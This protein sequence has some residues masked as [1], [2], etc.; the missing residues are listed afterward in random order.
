MIERLK[1][2][3]NKG[4]SE[5]Y[6]NKDADIKIDVENSSRPLP[7]NDIDTT[8]S[9]FEQFQ[10]EREESNTYRFYG[11]VSPLIS[12]PLY[13]DNIHIYEDEREIKSTKVISNE[14]FE[15]D[16][17]IGHFNDTGVNTY[18]DP[19]TLQGMFMGPLM[20]GSFSFDNIKI[21]KLPPETDFNNFYVGQS[22]EITYFNNNTGTDVTHT[23]IIGAVD[24]PNNIIYIQDTNNFLSQST[25]G[26]G[27]PTI[28]LNFIRDGGANDYNDNK[29]SICNFQPFDPG[30]DRLRLLDNDKH[31]NY[32]LKLTYPQ[33]SRDDIELI[34]GL[35]LSEGIPIM[36]IQKV[37][38]NGRDYTS[39]RT[40]IN[41]GLSKGDT[42]RLKHVSINNSNRTTFS[43]QR[44]GDDSN[45]N[46]F[47]MFVIDIDPSDVT[48]SVGQST[49]NRI[50]NGFNSQYYVRVFSGLTETYLDYDLY[51]AGYA[52]NYYEDQKVAFNFIKDIDIENVKDNLGR[53][54]SEIFLTIIKNNDDANL[55]D[56]RTQ[57]WI[58]KQ[59][60]KGLSTDFW[61]PIRGGFDIGKI[62]DTTLQYNIKAINDNE[63]PQTHFQNID[64]SDKSFIGDIVEYN[65]Y[66]L[67]ERILENSY[68]W[69]NTVYRENYSLFG[70]PLA[71]GADLINPEGDSDPPQPPQD[72]KEGYV[73]QPHN[74][75]IIK[76]YS[77]YIESGVPGEV[78][79]IPD[80][81]VSTYIS[82]GNTT[83]VDV[84]I[85]ESKRW[86]DMLS[87]GFMDGAGRGVDYPFESG[88]HYIFADTRFYLRRQDPA[89]NYNFTSTELQLPPDK[90][91]FYQILS[92]PSYF[93]YTFL[94][95]ELFDGLNPDDVTDLGALTISDDVKYAFER[96][97][98]SP[99]YDVFISL[100]FKTKFSRDSKLETLTMPSG[101]PYSQWC[102][103][104]TDKFVRNKGAG[105]DYVDES[106]FECDADYA[107][108]QVA[109]K[110]TDYFST[111]DSL[112]PAGQITNFCL[113]AA[114]IGQINL[115]KTRD[116]S[117]ACLRYVE[118]DVRSV[119]YYGEYSLGQVDTPG[120]CID[121]NFIE[122]KPID[123]DC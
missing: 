8:V 33:S 113:E 92:Q 123:D 81:A 72:K 63:Y 89:C 109:T 20:I 64:E 19:I 46:Q 88:A 35:P 4:R 68:H 100:N 5:T 114:G 77:S 18:T 24:A 66:E 93:D 94:N 32:L 27:T 29:S 30:Y 26:D 1:I 14:I 56:I 38:M 62:E 86:R 120:S 121:F 115:K 48:I 105:Q 10:K 36:E 58:D 21:I 40:P 37:R 43:V 104:I 65:E 79:N 91:L 111:C 50:V 107:W 55:S 102:P 87:V 39:F 49:V 67:L 15:N 71:L 106:S 99:C 76:E 78:I 42:I 61:V 122:E 98:K 59:S 12:N 9:S 73:Y 45:S 34:N 74:R 83:N 2:L 44:L 7:L 85:K 23:F 47:R 69:I 119:Q 60:E 97:P 3:L 70:P 28:E 17:W 84:K 80:Y 75:I 108:T 11:F 16:G 96:P 54:L 90:D 25:M 117:N 110:T 22:V 57:Y 41:H 6:V 118:I 95:Q 101:L 31:P 51:P 53:P 13:N 52:T 103:A 82:T 116:T 112:I